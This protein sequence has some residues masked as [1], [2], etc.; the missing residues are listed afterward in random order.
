MNKR[1]FFLVLMLLVVVLIVSVKIYFNIKN[2]VLNEYNYY[3]LLE[4]KVKEVYNLK[5]KYKL[6]K[7]RLNFLKKYCNVVNK[8]EKFL[9]ECKNLNQNNFNNIQN[10]LFKGNFKIKSFDI[11]KNKT[12]SIIA[13]IVK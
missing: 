11:D 6:N 3:I 8:G 7:N 13:E 12:V 5:Q 4:K 10:H 2:K 9:I 1:M